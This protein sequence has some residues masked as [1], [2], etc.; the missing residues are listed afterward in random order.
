M[1]VVRDV[2]FEMKLAILLRSS[3][4]PKHPVIERNVML[5]FERNLI[6]SS[7]SGLKFHMNSL[8]YSVGILSSVLWNLFHSLP[9]IFTFAKPALKRAPRDL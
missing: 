5:H 7:E 2:V 8:R 9:F 3:S 4:A 1:S 6:I